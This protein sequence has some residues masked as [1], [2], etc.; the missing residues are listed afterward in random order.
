MVIAGEVSRRRFLAMVGAGAT[1]MPA[2][3]LLAGCS[4]TSNTTLKVGALT[5][6]TG[7]LSATGA[8]VS[9]SLRASV[10]HLNAG[11][12]LGGRKVEVLLR[13]T[14]PSAD[15]SVRL[16]HEL[17]GDRSVVALLWCGS[18][19]LDQVTADIRG[20]A[21]PVVTVFDD[22]FSSGQLYPQSQVPGRSVF[23]ISPPAAHQLGALASYAATDRGYRSAGMIYD[24]AL[25]PAGARR[26]QFDRAFA[27]VGM[28][29][30]PPQSFTTGATDVGSQVGQLAISAPQVVYVDALP[31]DVA[32]VAQQLASSGAAYLDGPTAKGSL[33]RPQL[34]GS[35][36]GMGDG[37][38]ASTAGDAATVGSLTATH[39]G[40]LPYLPTFTV[41]SW[42]RRYLGVDA[43]GGEDGPADA[44]AAVLQGIKKAGST[45]RQKLSAA[46]ETLS[47]VRFASLPF[48]FGPRRH[49]AT[50]P[51]DVVILTLEDL[52]GAAPTDPS[53]QLGR[54]W[55]AGQLYGALAAAPTQLVRP[56]LAANRRAHPDVM[57]QIMAMG[58]GTQCTRGPGG[59]LTNA[60]KVH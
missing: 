38:W 55:R 22:L 59:Q 15:G 37:M 9:N 36:R 49:L 14:G 7:P 3:G 5:P 30:V 6:L 28:T 23:Q 17:V 42:L 1:V 60:C 2:T 51:D 18:P 26:A 24:A 19:G 11:G 13:D 21:L 45:D 54:E 57:G 25:D 12:G 46:I 39:L 34:F 4:S 10:R 35:L 32:T 40:A 58:F 27:G 41:G 33:W 48:G 44:L 47:T 52:R 53:Y 16:Y 8:M 56:T 50:V 31:A 29:V 43:T 20:Q